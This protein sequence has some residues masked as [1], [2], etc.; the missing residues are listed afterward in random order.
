MYF[1]I[2]MRMLN[3]VGVLS[4]VL[5]ATVNQEAAGSSPAWGA[6]L[7]GRQNRPRLSA[8]QS[9]DLSS[10]TWPGGDENGIIVAVQRGDLVSLSIKTSCPLSGGGSV[11]I[12]DKLSGDRNTP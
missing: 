8:F 12:H 2:A 6:N 1:P 4:L 10:D 7:G 3:L 5:R 9:P 11:N